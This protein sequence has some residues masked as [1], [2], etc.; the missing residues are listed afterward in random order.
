MVPSAGDGVSIGRSRAR[1]T[2]SLALSAV[3][4]VLP[5]A[6]AAQAAGSPAPAAP[7]A[8]AE[9]SARSY[10]LGSGLAV[11]ASAEVTGNWEA[12][13]DAWS[14]PVMFRISKVTRLGK[15]PVKLQ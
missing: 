5:G 13:K 4:F 6:V 10:N 8:T 15:R 12:D 3:L 7:A 1:V 14:G 2:T 9:P 11:G